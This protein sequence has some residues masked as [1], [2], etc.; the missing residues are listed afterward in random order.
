MLEL[1][2]IIVIIGVLSAI[3]IPKFA[4]NRDDAIV[5]KAKSTL[6]AVRSSIATE[7]QKRILRGKFTPITQLSEKEGDSVSLFNAFDGNTSLPVLE[8]SPISCKSSG[9]DGCWEI[10]QLGSNS[11]EAEYAF[12]LPTVG[13]AIKFKLQKNKFNCISDDKLCSKLTQ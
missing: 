2:F 1:I 6:S 9:Y 5:S 10:L 4:L 7:R 3:A 13:T 11:D 8:Y 12:N